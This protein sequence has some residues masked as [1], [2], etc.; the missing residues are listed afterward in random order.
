[1]VQILGKYIIIGYLDPQG[2]NT[3]I[4]GVLE[5]VV[6][7]TKIQAPAEQTIH[8]TGLSQSQTSIT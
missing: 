2:C 8:G 5:E 7:I 1:M 3:V 6:Y 4:M